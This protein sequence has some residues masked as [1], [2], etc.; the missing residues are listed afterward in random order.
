VVNP[1]IIAVIPAR[2]GSKGIPQKNIR[3]LKGQP[4][5][6]YSIKVSL[7]S[8]LIHR[9]V[10]STDSEEIASVARAYGA[11]APF[12]RPTEL[13]GDT[14]T[15]YEFVAHALDWFRK[16]EGRVPDYLVHLRPTTP[17]R[18]V[19]VVDAGIR[20]MISNPDATALR[21]VHEMSESAY[22]CFEI[23]NGFLKTVG[24]GSFHLDTA[25]QA[26]Q[27]FSKTYKG[28]GYVDVLKSAFVLEHHMIHGNRVMGFITSPVV[29]VDT[30]DE[31]ELLEYQIRRDSKVFNS[32]FG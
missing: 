19:E 5:I 7:R 28:N 24:T 13:A 9:T 3:P 29:E 20:A 8:P 1:A 11:E 23:R 4:L 31:F 22:K 26:R 12:L 21:S 32:L 25:N 27:Q 17:L 14:S 16:E 30:L 10:V 2:S 6:A 15:D 18:D